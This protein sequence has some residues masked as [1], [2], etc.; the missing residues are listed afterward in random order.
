MHKTHVLGFLILA[1]YN[2]LHGAEAAQNI[3]AFFSSHEFL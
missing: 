3:P 1:E 2:Q